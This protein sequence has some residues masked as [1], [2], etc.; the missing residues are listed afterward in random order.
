[1]LLAIERTL[2]LGLDRVRRAPQ[3]VVNLQT[4]DARRVA[5]APHVGLQ[6]RV[7]HEHPLPGEG[8]EKETLV[9]EKIVF[10]FQINLVSFSGEEKRENL[11]LLCIRGTSDGEVY[12]II[13]APKQL[14]ITLKL[15]LRKRSTVI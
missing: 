9:L 14:I 15:E 7:A 3:I 4:S 1:M 12:V 11:G 5:R 8:S 10:S 13:P 2:R 6:R